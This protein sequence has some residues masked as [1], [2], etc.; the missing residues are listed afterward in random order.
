[1]KLIKN[2]SL[3]ILFLLFLNAC[4]NQ[5]KADN[6]S[7]EKIEGKITLSGAFALYPLANVWAEEFRK[8]YPDVKFNIS[9]GGAGKG[10][11]DVLAGASD[12]ALYSKDISPVEVE[13]G[14]YGFAVTKDA[15]IPTISSQNPVIDQI[16]KEGLTR[17]TLASYFLEDGKKVWKNTKNEVNVYTRSDA[18]GAAEVWVKYL[19][20]KAQ[21]ELKGIAVFGDPGLAEAVKNDAK[22][23]GFNNVIYVYDLNSGEKYPGVDVAPIDINGNGTIDPEEDFYHNLGEI[24]KAIADGR[25]PSPPARELFLVSRGKPQ[26]IVVKT[27]LNWVLTKGQ[28]FV[29]PNGYILLENAKIA[30]EIKKL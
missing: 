17:E 3:S 20:G 28:A 7:A 15:V 29:V 8:E 18:S 30:T 24:T 22:G 11:A 26:S 14:A 21:E 16:K 4:N 5:K 25:Y 12:L 6:N 2:I 13:K 19:G 27:F 10:M 9:A 1:M 23:I